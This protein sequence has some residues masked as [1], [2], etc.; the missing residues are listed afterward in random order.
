[1][2]LSDKFREQKIAEYYRSMDKLSLETWQDIVACA[3]R[4]YSHE[5]TI[6]LFKSSGINLYTE[7]GLRLNASVDEIAEALNEVDRLS[8]YD[9]LEGKV[10][11][12][13]SL[14]GHTLDTVYIKQYEIAEAYSMAGETL[15]PWQ[16]FM[17]S[18][19][20]K[21]DVVWLSCEQ[22]LLCEAELLDGRRKAFE[23]IKASRKFATKKNGDSFEVDELLDESIIDL[24]KNENPKDDYEK[25]YLLETWANILKNERTRQLRLSAPTPSEDAIRK[26]TMAKIRCKT[27]EINQLLCAT[28]DTENDGGFSQAGDDTKANNDQV[29]TPSINDNDFE[30]SGL[31]NIPKNAG[32]WAFAI[33]DIARDFCKQN[34]RLPNKAEAWG[35]L[36]TSPPALYFITVGKDKRLNM[37]SADPLTQRAF[38]ERWKRYT[39]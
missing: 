19:K 27:K 7:D 28:V 16:Q 10:F 24:L 22:A 12:L 34:E 11:N 35:Q 32:N 21:D 9:N 17:G 8:A 25:H 4:G 23:K 38:N 13:V 15:F 37:S 14:D 20:S 3:E 30:F 2:G 33:D 29:S 5:F 31:L 39:K 18:V 6:Q 1:M 36:C 26:E